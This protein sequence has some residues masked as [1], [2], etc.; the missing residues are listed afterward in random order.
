MGDASSTS[1]P[2]PATICV[3][4]TSRATKA[5][6]PRIL[7]PYHTGATDTARL[8]ALLAGTKAVK[9]FY[10]TGTDFPARTVART[11]SV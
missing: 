2:G 11:D 5:F 4:P 1:V 9:Q 6:A 10:S 3:C 7:Y 8:T